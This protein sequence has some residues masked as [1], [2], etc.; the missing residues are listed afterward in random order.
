MLRDY[1]NKIDVLDSFY[2]EQPVMATRNDI[3]T[4]LTLHSKSTQ[5]T[6]GLA[7]VIPPT[8]PRQWIFLFD[9]SFKCAIPDFT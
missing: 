2:C 5:S 8:P 1:C 7:V 6:R 4:I 9:F 3:A